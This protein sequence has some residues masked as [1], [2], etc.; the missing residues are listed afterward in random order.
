MF[1]DHDYYNPQT[2]TW[3]ELSDMPM[4]IH[5]IVGSAFVDGL[6]WAPGGGTRLV[7]SSN[8]SGSTQIWTM[9]A[10]G[11]GLHQLTTQG[12]NEKPVWSK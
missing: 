5:G 3:T 6:I 4:P 1:P 10:N 9:L 12:Q 7:F 11:T 2:N 8:R